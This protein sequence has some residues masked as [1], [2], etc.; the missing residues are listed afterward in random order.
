[1]LL[2]LGLTMSDTDLR[3]ASAAL[4]ADGSGSISFSE[5]YDWFAGRGGVSDAVDALELLSD[6]SSWSTGQ[7]S[8]Y[9]GRTTPPLTSRTERSRLGGPPSSAASSAGRSM[10]GGRTWG[11]RGTG[12][13]ARSTFAKVLPPCLATALKDT[14]L[15]CVEARPCPV[16]RSTGRMT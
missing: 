8:D 10:T 15:P 6:G 1:M 4:D 2:A 16:D 11:P 5:F 13:V 3:V 12:N 14:S 9:Y 7:R